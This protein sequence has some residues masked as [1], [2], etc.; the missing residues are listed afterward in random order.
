MTVYEAIQKRFSCRSYKPDPVPREIIE[1]V[2]AMAGQ[3]PSA[4]N[5][6]PW[7]FIVLT[8]PETRNALR[9]A[10]DREWFSTAPVVIAACGLMEEGWKRSWDKEDF[11]RVDVAIA[12]DHLTLAAVQEGLATCWIGA[13]K[14]D[15]AEKILGVPDGVKIVA[16]TP[17][18]YP[19]A[20]Q[21]ER[22]RKPL[23][24]ILKWEKW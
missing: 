19:A 15:I 13:F 2:I 24:E 7:K 12:F 23:N 5:L 17:L 20:V 3:A 16:M 6:Q 1:K 8:D 10:Y 22:S 18:G 9:Q 4:K 21:P 11:T 14:E